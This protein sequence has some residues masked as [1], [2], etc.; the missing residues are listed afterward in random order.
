MRR[1]S[2]LRMRRE[3]SSF[4]FLTRWS[5]AIHWALFT[6]TSNLRI[7]CSRAKTLRL[8]FSKSPTSGLLASLTM[9]LWRRLLVVRLAMS[10][11][12]C[13][14]SNRT[15]MHVTSGVWE[16]SYLFCWAVSLPFS[17]KTTLNFSRR[18]SEPSSISKLK[19]G[20][21]FQMKPRALFPAFLPK[22][23]TKESK[24]LTSWNT[25]G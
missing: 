7:Y 13:L 18:S 24:G 16:L 22:I 6:G 15:T 10:R 4:P 9:R 21:T 23:Q 14:C 8:Q 1:R 17:M 2:F 11:L 25:L 20:R 3:K 19:D 5:T 12:K